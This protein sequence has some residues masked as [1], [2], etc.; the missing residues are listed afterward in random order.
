MRNSI[1]VIAKKPKAL[2]RRALEGY[3]EVDDRRGIAVALLNLGSLEADL[4]A[5]FAAARVRFEE[6]LAVFRELG[7]SINMAMTLANLGEVCAHEGDFQS[8]LVYANESLKV[9][10]R[11]GNESMGAWQL[12][13]IAVYRI[14][15]GEYE[16]A[17]GALRTAYEKLSV[18]HHVEF[19][20]NYCDAL[21]L[22]LW[23]LG[24][25]EDAAQVLGFVAEYRKR[26]HVPRLA[27]SLSMFTGCAD[28]VS[29][30]LDPALYENL[31]RQGA[32]LTFGEIDHL[33][34]SGAAAVTA[35]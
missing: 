16:L 26:E 6:S 9:S 35:P 17:A 15:R 25:I 10:Q 34:R 27:T 18:Q 29:A 21:S 32:L 4:R 20:A 14:E 11:L 2:Y 5:D 7:I 22:L 12:T 23:K 33:F 24:R 31:M 3:R 8:A 19:I 13:N 1:P 30:A 28:A